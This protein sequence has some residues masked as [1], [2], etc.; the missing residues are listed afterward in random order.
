VKTVGGRSVW[1]LSEVTG[2]IWRRFEDIPPVWVEA[3]VQN[4]RSTGG[5]TYFTLAGGDLM[6]A[7]MNRIVFDRLPA[8]PTEGT[9]VQ[10]YGRVEFWRARSLVRMRVERMELAGEGLLRAQVEELRRRLGA[11]GLLEAA[12][13]RA[14][15][16]LPRRIG[17]VTS[18]QGAAKEDFLRAL[19]ARFPADVLLVEVPVQGESAPAAVVRAIRHLDAR[20]D[21]DVIVVARGGGSLEDLMAFNSEAVCRAVAATAT[22]I[23]SAVGHERDVTLCDEVADVRVSTPTAAAQ[24]VAPDAAELERGL[25]GAE[26]TLARV[27]MRVRR[28]AGE[29]LALRTAALGRALRARGARSADRV[30]AAGRRLAPALAR[31]VGRAPERLAGAEAALTRATLARAAGAGERVARSAA[32]LALLSPERTVA[33]GYAIVR[34]AATDGVI[35]AAAAAE[36]GQALSIQLRDGRLPAVVGS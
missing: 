11:E 22:P 12:R 23:V 18:G 15:P 14:L 35:G 21:V 1:S 25:R 9:L 32:L 2:A 5:Q 3:E 19:W 27:L 8:K 24:A 7:S 13:K 17:L 16:M 30:D 31:V 6:D 33:R 34:D 36:P 28:V 4:L 29:R 10:A 26:E 20:A